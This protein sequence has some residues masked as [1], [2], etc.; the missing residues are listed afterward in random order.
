VLAS[1]CESL[2]LALE[3][4]GAALSLNGGLDDRATRPPVRSD[5]RAL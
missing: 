2:L 4:T 5:V 1:V 3:R